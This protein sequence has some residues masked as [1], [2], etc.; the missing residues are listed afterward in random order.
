MSQVIV[1]G[2]SDDLICIG[3]DVS[4]EFEYQDRENGDLIAFS[5]GTVLRIGFRNDGTW[6]I[7][8][9]VKGAADL[10]IV[11][12]PEDDE[13]VYSDVATVNFGDGHKPWVVHGIAVAR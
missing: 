2:G 8:P 3:G 12:A 13:D 9:V 5:D 10:G 11:L 6:R 7:T 4:E 1:T